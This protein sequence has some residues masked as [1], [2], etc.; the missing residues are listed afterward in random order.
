MTKLLWTVLINVAVL[1]VIAAA[2]V[3]YV[4]YYKSGESRQLFEPTLQGYRN[5]QLI[6][7]TPTSDTEVR[8]LIELQNKLDLLPWS[9]VLRP[10]WPAT[11]QVPPDQSKLLSMSTEALHMPFVLLSSNMEEYLVNRKRVATEFRLD[12]ASDFDLNRYHFNTEIEKYLI[13]LADEQTGR[14]IV[15]PYGSSIEA[16]T[17]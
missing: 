1:L 11:F 10:G 7:F 17:L 15:K 5:H 3:C 6:Q 4:L 2:S 12:K 13:K 9:R 8:K 16:R 14:L